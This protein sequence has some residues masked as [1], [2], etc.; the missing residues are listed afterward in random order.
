MGR[1][2]IAQVRVWRSIIAPDRTV[3]GAYVEGQYF[4]RE[5]QVTESALEE[6]V[7]RSLGWS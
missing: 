5:P 4:P 3:V 2:S 6:R 7:R 1:A